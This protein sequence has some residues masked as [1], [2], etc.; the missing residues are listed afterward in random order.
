[1]KERSI[2]K[3]SNAPHTS[4]LRGKRL[5]SLA[6]AMLLTVMA[7][8]PLVSCAPPK[9]EEVKDIYVDLI[10][11]SEDINQILFGD[12]L[13]VYG[14]MSYDEEREIYYYVF[15]TKNEGKLCAYFDKEQM[16]YVTL[17]FGEAGEGAVYSDSENGIYL[18]PSDYE[19]ND[20]AGLLPEAPTDYRFVRFDE[21][22][23]SLSA[24]SSAAAEV[25]SE[26]FLRDVFE[27]TL[28]ESV[29]SDYV[30]DN[31]F[32]SKY[33]ELIDEESGKKFLLRATAKACPPISTEE[34]EYDFDSMKI[35]K[36]SRKDFVKIEIR[37][38]GTYLDIEAVAI[39]TGWSTIEL[40]FVLQNGEWRLD[41]PTY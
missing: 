31:I 1:M 5:I 13:S 22:Y 18:Y 36:R 38:Y 30:A 11:R 10:K 29:S 28:G 41:S 2:K 21:R 37:T 23:V 39:K 12:G 40:S 17:R 15:Y 33:R 27:N 32:V 34:R 24:L 9:L 7:A 19:Y 3:R 35:A 6:L 26:E 16:E 20:D 14:D 4:A 8:M 25:Y